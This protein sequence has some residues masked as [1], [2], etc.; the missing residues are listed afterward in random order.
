[1]QVDP[2]DQFQV[3]LF[4]Q[5]LEMMKQLNY[6]IIQQTQNVNQA[7]KPPENQNGSISIYA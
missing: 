4:K 7:K 6:Q 5:V 1:M 3:E 2:V